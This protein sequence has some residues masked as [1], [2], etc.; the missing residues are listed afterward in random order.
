MRTRPDIVG[1]CLL[2]LLLCGAAAAQ[3]PQLRVNWEYTDAGGN[4]VSGTIVI[5]DGETL[6][7]V[8]EQA[9]LG[10]TQIRWRLRGLDPTGHD[11]FPDIG[12]AVPP[13]PPGLRDGGF[14]N[15]GG[16]VSL[17]YSVTA[18]P[19]NAGDPPRV[20]SCTL[21]VTVEDTVP[22]V[23]SSVDCDSP[24][25]PTVSVGEG[26][27]A[28]FIDPTGDGR[29]VDFTANVTDTCDAAPTVVFVPPSGTTFYG[30]DT[31]VTATATDASGNFSEFHFV[32]RIV[33]PRGP[34]PPIMLPEPTYT[35][36]TSNEVAWS[37][38]DATTQFT[39]VQVSDSPAFATVSDS[40]RTTVTGADP[41][42]HT[43]TG[44]ADAVEYFYRAR[45]GYSA[46][47]G[48]DVWGSWSNVVSSIQDSQAPVIVGADM[49]VEQEDLAGTAIVAATWHQTTRTDWEGDIRV[50]VDIDSIPGAVTLA[51]LSPP[52]VDQIGD[53]SQTTSPTPGGIAINYFR[54]SQDSLLVQIEHW[55]DTSTDQDLVFAVYE[56]SD[57]AGP[58]SG[59]YSDIVR[60]EATGPGFYS[61]G[62]LAV[63][64]QGGFYYAIGVSW[65]AGAVRWQDGPAGAYSIGTWVGDLGLPGPG[66]LTPEAGPDTTPTPQFQRLTTIE[67]YVR[68]GTIQTPPIEPFP[69]V[70]QWG[71]LTFESQEPGD[72]VIT[73]DV[74]DAG[75]T[76]VIA[77]VASGTDLHA[78]GVDAAMYPQICLRATLESPSGYYSPVLSSWT[79]GYDN[80]NP[81]G[82]YATDTADPDFPVAAGD[83]SG[84]LVGVRSDGQLV[85]D[86]FP[87]GTT[88]VTWTAEDHFGPSFGNVNPGGHMATLVQSV[89]VVDTTDPTVTLMPGGGITVAAPDLWLLEQDSLGGATLNYAVA[90]N[91]AC[92]SAPNRT[93]S[94][95]P[96]AYLNLGN[97]LLRVIVTDASG[98][99]TTRS[100]TVRVQDTTPPGPNLASPPPVVAIYQPNPDSMQP[101]TWADVV[102]G[103]QYRLGL[104]DLPGITPANV[105]DVCDSSPTILGHDGADRTF[106]NGTNVIYWEVV[107]ASGNT[108]Y[109][110]Q[111]L[112]IEPL[113]PAPGGQP[114]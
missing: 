37:I 43:F 47:L 44:L 107:D 70:Q 109:V 13:N 75:G 66:T 56:A 20:S 96:G 40:Y 46:P 1:A 89:T 111:V 78:A 100:V 5:S 60:I 50:D 106:V 45:A 17:V 15:L 53:G 77:G 7:L 59:L 76:V 51:T 80:G 25:D 72:S 54:A 92:D 85:T 68:S 55:I 16:P 19:L 49:V 69:A 31:P 35:E 64:I 41:E 90:V 39:Q 6:P 27:I 81:L 62:P 18:D 74:L 9:A 86:P 34:E 67:G 12:Y 79:V 101:Y 102:R 94:P 14:F 30:G 103:L 83:G 110:P 97:H 38:T 52:A 36:G 26:G 22:P 87:L 108:G 88:T 29:V 114:H 65:T 23:I 95:G 57:I 3:N 28:E 32:V 10:G 42:T 24:P 82:V 33:P 8:V 63:E 11:L 4:L 61:S 21:A 91:D 105:Y 73:V 104:P 98:N 2:A 112:L 58:W 93:G 84:K 113:A 48:A 71:T 99:T